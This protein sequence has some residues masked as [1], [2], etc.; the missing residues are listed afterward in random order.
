[1]QQTEDICSLTVPERRVRLLGDE[2]S[3]RAAFSRFGPNDE[4]N[5]LTLAKLERLGQE[6]EILRAYSDG[7]VTV[8]FDDGVEH[9]MPMEA[10]VAHARSVPQIVET[11]TDFTATLKF[12]DGSHM[13][14][15]HGADI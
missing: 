12:W 7:T 14:L 1:M 13:M 11:F 3:F 5:G 10:C 8:R 6:A 2:T 9:D 15:L 4:Q